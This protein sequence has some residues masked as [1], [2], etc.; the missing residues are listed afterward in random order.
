VRRYYANFSY[1]AQ[2]WTKVRR[3]VAKVEWHPGELYPRVD[4][5]VTNMMRPAKRVV[6][7]YNKRGTAEQ[8]IKEFKNA[9]KSTRLSCCSF[10]ADAVRVQLHML[11][12]NLAKF[13]QTLALPEAVK[14]WSLTSLQEKLVKIAAKVVC[15]GRYVIFEMAEVAVPKELFREILRLIDR[16]RPRAAPAQDWGGRMRHHNGRRG[17]EWRGKGP[18][19]WIKRRLGLRKRRE[20]CVSRLWFPGKPTVC[21]RLLRSRVHLGNVGLS[22]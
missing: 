5:I 7:F 2:R 6:A 16:L 19:R 3:L 8:W 20:H 14:Q 22:P 1:Q 9:I 11:A 10:A 4:F 12:Y 13:M 15:Q 17:S 18:N 21:F